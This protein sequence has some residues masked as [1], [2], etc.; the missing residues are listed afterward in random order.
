MKNKLLEN[1]FTSGWDF[2]EDDSELKNKFQMVNI[3]FLLSFAGLIFGISANILRATPALIPVETVL[4]LSAVGLMLALR[5][6]KK[7][8]KVISFLMTLQYSIL[9]LLL[10]YM[11]K[12]EELKHIWIFT[13]PIILLY[14]GSDRY[15]FFWVAAMVF[16]LLIA[17]IQPFVHVSYSLFQVTYI[18][19]VLILVSIIIYFYQKR[20]NEAASLIIEQKN[21]LKKQLDELTKK[22]KILSVQ[23]KQAVMGEMI[24]MIAH[25]WRQPLSTVTLNI[26]NLQIKR[27][28]GKEI[29]EKEYETAFEEINNTIAYLSATI[30]D[31]Q[32]YFHPKKEINSIEINELIQKAI[33]F[34][35]PR[36]KETYIK[37]LYMQKNSAVINTYTNELIQVLLNILNNAVD[38]LI[39]REIK[40]PKIIIRVQNRG[41]AL[42]LEIEDNAG[43]I[44]K[45]HIDSIFEPYFST[46]GKNGTGLGLYMSQMIMQKQF[47]TTIE[48]ESEKNSTVF[49]FTVPKKLA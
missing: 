28:L 11:S 44:K 2:K 17:P 24:S 47:H 20:M 48:V 41:D 37:I 23:S 35:K 12:P 45:E 5:I 42:Q 14:F 30:D 31:F 34:T 36:L 25:Q 29:R 43:G 15:V 26:S 32:T 1:F 10:V 18:S 13:Y 40:D 38:E 46:K 39:A 9:F 16:F 7:Y 6:N 27:L 19:F 3:V 21:M 8:F 49:H 33:N 4:L 22:D